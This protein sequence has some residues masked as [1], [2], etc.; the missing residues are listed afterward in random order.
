MDLSGYRA[1]IEAALKHGGDLYRY[2]DI[3][4]LVDEGLAQAWPGEK[5][6]AIT[7]ILQ[8]PVK[9]VLHFWVVGG[10]LGE[11]ESRYAELEAFAKHEGCEG[12]SLLGRPGWERTFLARTGWSKTAVFMEK[13]CLDQ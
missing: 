10:E 8:Y 2:E 6:I 4:K 7:Q 3:Q 9:K 5:S 11:I 1:Q 13:R 12:L